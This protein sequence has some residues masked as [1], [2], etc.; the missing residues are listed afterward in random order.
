MENERRKGDIKRKNKRTSFSLLLPF[1]PFHL[2]GFMVLGSYLFLLR[3]IAHHAN[4]VGPE[5]TPG[6]H[7]EHQDLRARSLVPEDLVVQDHARDVLD[8]PALFEPRA[9][10]AK[11]DELGLV[12]PAR[13]EP[14]LFLGSRTS[15]LPS[16]FRSTVNTRPDIFTFRV[17]SHLLRQITALPPDPEITAS[18]PVRGFIN[19]PACGIF[20]FTLPDQ[21][22]V[23]VNKQ[24]VLVVERDKERAGSSASA[25]ANP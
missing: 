4:A 14:P 3:R 24:L 10:P 6:R 7:H 12:I 25:Y 17:L 15:S 20:F 1:P 5:Q 9:C 8:V 2:K 13:I 23:G 16:P 19:R 18:M 22:P 21:R 11:A